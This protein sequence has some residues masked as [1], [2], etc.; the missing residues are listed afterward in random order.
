MRFGYILRSVL[1]TK[2]QSVR[3]AHHTLAVPGRALAAPWC[4]RT[5]SMNGLWW[6]WPKWGGVVFVDGYVVVAVAGRSLNRALSNSP[7]NSGIGFK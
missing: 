6:L 5:I 3:L 2:L 1:T 4:L 7:R